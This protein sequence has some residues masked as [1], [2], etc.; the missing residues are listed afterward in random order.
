MNIVKALFK[1]QGG[2]HPKYNK[3]LSRDKSIETMPVSTLLQVSMSQHLGAPA[4]PTVKKGDTVLRGQQIGEAAGFISAA[5]HAPTSGTVK[6]IVVAATAAGSTVPAIEIEPDG[7]DKWIDGLTGIADWKNS[8]NK[9]LIAKVAEAGISG[10]GGAG[11]PT[12][13]KLSPPP[14]KPIDTLIINGAECEPYLTADHRLMV[15]YAAEIRTGIEIISKILS[16]KTVRVAIESNKP[17]AIEAMGKAL[18]DIDGDVEIAILKTEYPQGAEKQQI[19]AIT[20]KEVPSAGLP[21]DVGCVVENV[22]TTLAIQDA[23]IN[24]K[25]VT[26]RVTTVTGTPVTSPKNVLV[27]LGTSY[28]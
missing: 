9:E 4:T 17:E 18:A 27:R 24:G 15:E 10:M 2:I 20:G 14:N 11:F 22:G 28:A 8:D 16:V 12:H 3:E 26:E 7:E 6:A 1:S 13:V 25:P 23:I 5:V 21:M 19:F